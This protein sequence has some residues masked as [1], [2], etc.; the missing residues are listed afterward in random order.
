MNVWIVFVGETLPMDEAT[1]TWRYGILAQTLAARGHHV[2]RWAPTFNHS[3]K[4]QRYHTDYTY[5]VNE[6][7]KIKL[8][9]NRGYKRNIGFQR[10]LSYIQLAHSFKRRIKNEKPPDIIISGMPTSWLCSVAINY[11][12]QK[13][14]PVVIDIRDLWPDIFVD[15]FP[16]YLKKIG[17]LA[18]DVFNTDIFEKAIS[19][20][21]IS[22][23]YLAWG[24]NYANRAKTENDCIFYM[25]YKQKSLTD[26]MKVDLYK[27]WEKLGVSKQRF[28]CCFFGS[29]NRQFNI[30]NI[31][32]A[33][34]YLKEIK[35]DEVLFVMC[36]DGTHLTYYKNMAK[37]FNNIIF[38]GWVGI[39]QI[40]SLMQIS[41]V[42]LAPYS[43]SAKMSLPNKPFE[44]FSGGLPVLSSLHDELEQ[45]LSE[46]DCGL[47]YEAG[48]VQGL[49]DTILY[50][51]NNPE[52][53][54]QMGKNAKR[55]FEEKYIA[56]KIY[57]P[58][59]DH[60]EKLVYGNDK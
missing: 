42:G 3:H 5:E 2:T 24:L 39:E 1:R 48:D 7:Y 35:S 29:I 28:I 10:L 8:I 30:K 14:I 43:S 36:G 57:P 51:K 34:K 13:N 20:T 45:I 38:P 54:E 37:E 60:M 33:A 58:M 47:T 16:K 25:G 19:I 50:L 40:Q 12:Q 27:F 21:A 53:R 55:L 6:N 4:K 46:N 49:V 15:V 18:L 11:G 44:Y 59:A 9:Y 23:K 56:D 52:K 41:E 22:P 31:I 26:Q 32:H 17:K